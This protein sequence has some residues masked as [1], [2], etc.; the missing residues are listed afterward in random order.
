MSHTY[1]ESLPQE[2]HVGHPVVDLRQHVLQVLGGDPAGETHSGGL[3]Q[4]DLTL[5]LG[6]PKGHQ[7]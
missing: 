6:H 3:G 2:P 1:R 5:G 4:R 7:L